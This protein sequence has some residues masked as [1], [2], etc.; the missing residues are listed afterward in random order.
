[1]G[2]DR[3]SALERFAYRRLWTV[4]ETMLL[5]RLYGTAPLR[6]LVRSFPGRTIEQLQSKA[7]SLLLSEQQVTRAHRWT[8][9]EL[10][11]LRYLYP[12]TPTR[13]LLG[14][15]PGRCL[16]SLTNKATR[17]GLLKAYP[18]PRGA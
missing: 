17:L 3:F 2:Q 11:R 5:R 6:E 10:D 4:D 13:E 15:F 16:E 9:S 18:P 8:A 7:R 14:L 1:M 12:T